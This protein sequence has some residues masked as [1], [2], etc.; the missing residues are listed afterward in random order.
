[1]AID[2]PSVETTI[3]F[4]LKIFVLNV[5]VVWRLNGFGVFG[6]VLRQPCEVTWC[7]L[8]KS[9]ENRLLT[10]KEAILRAKHSNISGKWNK[11]SRVEDL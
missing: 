9:Y 4:R 10:K 6:I 5:I 8:D 1:M 3:G 7:F 11:A 2:G